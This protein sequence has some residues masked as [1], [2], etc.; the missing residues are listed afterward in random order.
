MQEKIKTEVI[1]D[2]GNEHNLEVVLDSDVIDFILDGKSVFG[3]D[4]SNNFAKLFKRALEI[5]GGPEEE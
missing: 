5:W 2:D 3:G 4:Y 1:T